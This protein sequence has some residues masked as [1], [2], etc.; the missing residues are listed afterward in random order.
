[1]QESILNY[2]ICVGNFYYKRNRFST[3]SLVLQLA[4]LNHILDNHLTFQTIFQAKQAEFYSGCLDTDTSK[5][6]SIW[7]EKDVMVPLAG[8]NTAF[9]YQVGNDRMDI[10]FARISKCTDSVTEGPHRA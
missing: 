6:D 4:A 2:I 3:Y 1:M 9:V 5:R 7:L 8:T 10:S